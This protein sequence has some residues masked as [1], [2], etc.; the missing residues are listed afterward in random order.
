MLLSRWSA[1]E[2]SI[3]DPLHHLAS[4][5]QVRENILLQPISSK[6]T[7]LEKKSYIQMANFHVLIA[8]AAVNHGI[9]NAVKPQLTMNDA[10]RKKGNCANEMVL[11]VYVYV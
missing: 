2:P 5:C 11:Y 7:E 6:P 10:L 9:L 8:I 4:V 3:S 1:C